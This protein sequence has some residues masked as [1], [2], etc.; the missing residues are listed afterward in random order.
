MQRNN[1]SIITRR[2]GIVVL[3]THMHIYNH[4][5]VSIALLNNFTKLLLA[6]AIVFALGAL[7]L[8]IVL[9]TLQWRHNG[10]NGVSDHR[11]L[12]CLLSRLFRLILKKIFKLRVTGL[13]VENSSVNGEFPAHRA[14]DAE[15]VS[16]RWRHHDSV[17][18]LLLVKPIHMNL[19]IVFL[20]PNKYN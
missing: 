9:W 3:V 18:L 8:H 5:L 4:M 12:D 7:T 2:P 16:I 19:Q 10:R 15:N 14:S 20:L 6:V 13:C 11:V 17:A 1:L